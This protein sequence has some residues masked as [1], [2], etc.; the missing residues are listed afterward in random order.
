MFN[1]SVSE[2]VLAREDYTMLKLYKLPGYWRTHVATLVS[3]S[4]HPHRGQY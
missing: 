1:D 4:Y 2:G 3:R